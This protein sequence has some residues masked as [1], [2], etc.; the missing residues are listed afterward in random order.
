MVVTKGLFWLLLVVAVTAKVRYDKYQ[1]FRLKPA[2]HKQLEA[3]R[4][5]E[6]ENQ[7]VSCV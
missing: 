6:K 1:V 2:D 7:G 4:K 3:L 5:L